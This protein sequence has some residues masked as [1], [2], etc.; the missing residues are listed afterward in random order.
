MSLTVRRI[1]TSSGRHGQLW[2]GRRYLTL[3]SL[4]GSS[5]S[6]MP[7]LTPFAVRWNKTLD[8][9]ISDDPVIHLAPTSLGSPLTRLVKHLHAHVRQPGDSSWTVYGIDVPP[10]NRAL[11][12]P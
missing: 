3:C 9:S 1:E 6:S 10:A 12:E 4:V 7:R 8:R 5:T 2:A 11:H